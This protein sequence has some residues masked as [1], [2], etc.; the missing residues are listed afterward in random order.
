MIL[1]T[2]FRLASP[3]GPKARLS[4]L[5]FHRVHAQ[6]DQ[7][8]P[9]EMHA[10]RFNAVCTWLSQWFNVLPLG[11]AVKQLNAGILPARAACITFDDGYADNFHIAMPVLRKHGLNATFFVAAGFLDGGCM[12]NDSIIESVRRSQC[13]SLD[14]AELGLGLSTRAIGTLGAKRALIGDLIDAIKY[15]TTCERLILVDR[16][17]TLAQVALPSDLMMRADDVIG[18]RD[19][20]MLIGA[21]TLSHPILAKASDSEAWTEIREGKY[22]LERILGQPVDYFAYPNG[23]PGLD[24]RQL[25]VAMAR[26]A[27]FAAAVSTSPGASSQQSDIYQL[28]RFTPWDITRTRFGARLLVNL[29]NTAAAVA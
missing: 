26:D 28:P 8:F 24:Y 9:N 29:R 5:I 14:L 12:W 27:G 23:K 13:E 6:P 16:L 25:H 11:H 10:H 7:L 22:A 15:R 18:L 20:G 17:A 19:G 3:A 4:I 1:R 2:A 21:H